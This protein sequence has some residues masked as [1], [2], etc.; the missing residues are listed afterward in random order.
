M[1]YKHHNTRH[2]ETHGRITSPEFRA[3]IEMRRRCRS[4]KGWTDRGITVCD[5]WGCF[6]NF[7]AD[8]GRKPSTNHSLDR[9]DN[10][11]NY[12]PGNCRWATKLE[13]RLNRRE[14]LSREQ[15]SEIL[16]RRA[17]GESCDD[18]GVVFGVDPSAISRIA[19]G[20]SYQH[21]GLV[22]LS[23]ALDIRASEV[24]ALPQA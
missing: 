5:R 3:W 11:G 14:R 13:Q 12:M 8:M 21:Y 23:R 18:L 19:C 16:A 22:A 20:H 6:E 2:G 4:R 10:S 1:T 24:K 7:L 9:I 17:D 15:V